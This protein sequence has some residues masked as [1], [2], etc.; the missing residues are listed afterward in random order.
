[1]K[2]NKS[3][4]QFYALGNKFLSL[5]TS[6]LYFKR[7]TDMETCYKMFKK[8]VIDS[9][10]ITRNRFDMEP[11]ITAKVLKKGY[12]LKEVPITYIGR[13]KEEGKK[14]GVKDGIIALW[15]LIKYR[16]VN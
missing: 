13:S 14:I 5:A 15:V 10:K 6:L 2:N 3:R 12:K 9:I 4:Y 8:E 1:M 16:F 11:E 7:I